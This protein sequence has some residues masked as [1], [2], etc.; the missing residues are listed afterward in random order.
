MNMKTQ[1][2]GVCSPICFITSKCAA[3]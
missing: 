2:R 3:S 1:Y